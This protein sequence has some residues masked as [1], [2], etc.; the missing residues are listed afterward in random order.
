MPATRFR[1]YWRP[2]AAALA[3]S[4]VVLGYRALYPVPNGFLAVFYVALVGMLYYTLVGAATG[5]S[6]ER[7]PLPQ[8]RL[9]AVVPSFN[10][11]PIV[12]HACIDSLLAQTRPPD[13][14]YVVDDGSTPPAPRYRHPTV[15][16]I[17]ICNSG[18]RLAQ[19]AALNE[20]EAARPDFLL[21]VDSDSIV[22]RT[23]CEDTLRAFSDSRVQGATGMPMLLNRRRNLLTRVCDIEFV[24]A[25]RIGRSSK[26]LIG[27]VCPASGAFAMYR[28]Q[29]IYKNLADYAT[30]GNVGDDRRLAVYAL[31][32]GHMVA[33]NSAQV[34]VVMPTR[35]RAAYWQRKRWFTA[36]W[37][38]LP[39][40]IGVLPTRGLFFRT[41]NLIIGVCTPLIL[42]WLFLVMP[43]VAH[44]VEWRGAAL[45][46]ALSYSQTFTYV[47]ARPKT[48]MPERIVAWIWLTPMLM[49]WQLFVI[50][51]A[52]VHALPT[53]QSETWHGR[54]VARRRH[55]A[56]PGR[57]RS[58]WLPHERSVR[59]RR[60]L[61]S[62][63]KPAK[64]A[65]CGLWISSL[66]VT[67]LAGTA[68]HWQ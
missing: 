58:P 10:E 1:R 37:R 17:R 18:K 23:A 46:A 64:Y 31:R 19:I 16:W 50:R 47:A 43:F 35:L 62:L 7:L 24:S 4:A 9:A 48:T 2:A 56:R 51:P 8:G 26:S 32:Y 30:S 22:S 15:R 54:E 6:F 34:E 36:Y 53:C 5:R 21:T 52:L 33:V 55:T 12:L 57:R 39:W 68:A 42:L 59:L 45:W 29:I 49:L 13:I 27:A 14:I 11:D 20:E 3:C 66:L 67:L 63:M 28:A 41:W 44:R 38:F 40:E 61:T 25:S 65:F 60:R